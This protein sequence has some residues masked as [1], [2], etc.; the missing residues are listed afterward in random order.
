VRDCENPYLITGPALM[1]FSGGRT[2]GYLL[3]QII[4]AH[5]GALPSDIVVTFCNTGKERAETL[6]FVAECS[7]RWNVPIVWLEWI[8]EEP[9]Y[10]IVSHNS[11]S[12]NGEP[13]RAMLRQHVKRRD[14]TVGR[15][16]LPTMVASSCTSNL[17]T[18]L[19]WRYARKEMGW[20]TYTNAIGF[21]ADEAHRF[22]S[23]LKYAETGETIACPMVTMGVTE[24]DVMAFWAKQPFDLRLKQYEG[25]CDLCFKKSAGKISRIMREAPER[26]QWWINVEA[27]AA[28]SDR[29]GPFRDDRPNYAAMLDAVRRQ[30]E[31][32]FG[33]FDDATTCGSHGCTD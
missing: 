15:R 8:E 23:A 26:A 16:P 31:F 30:D 17:K 27:E 11:A 33:P 18:R 32:D 4:Q 24:R 14:G 22:E 1:S 3:Y 6:D 19:K 20:Q 21:R 13:F 7:A 10:Q 12:R 5:G 28:A 2:S 29:P 9:G 25:N